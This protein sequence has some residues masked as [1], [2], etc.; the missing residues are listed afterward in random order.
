MYRVIITIFI[1][2]LNLS[3]NELMLYTAINIDTNESC[4]FY[5]E[6]Q[7]LEKSSS[8]KGQCN[9]GFIDGNVILKHH[10]GHKYIGETKNGYYHGRG[11]FYWDENHYVEGIFT[12]NYV[13]GKAKE[14]NNGY[15]FDGEFYRNAFTGFGSYTM[16]L[17]KKFVVSKGK[18]E[19]IES[20]RKHQNC[21]LNND[22]LECLV[23][24]TEI[25]KQYLPNHPILSNEYA[26]IA[27]L[28]KDNGDYNRSIHYA[29]KEFNITKNFIQDDSTIK[30]YDVLSAMYTKIND[31]ENA[32][33]YLEKSIALERKLDNQ[34]E[35]ARKYNNLATTYNTIGKFSKSLESIN[36][37]L[38]IC[39]KIYS[40]YNKNTAIAYSTRSL[41]YSSLGRFKESL[42]DAKKSL[43]IS[44]NV[45]P[46][47]MDLAIQYNIVALAY[48]KLANI[49]EAKKYYEKSLKLR[50]KLLGD[51]HPSLVNIY[52][53]LSVLYQNMGNFDKAEK[54]AKEAL[55]NNDE[56]NIHFDREKQ[57]LIYYNLATTY[58]DKGNLEKAEKYAKKSLD[59]AQAISYNSKNIADIYNVLGMIYLDKNSTAFAK[60]YMLK[61]LDLNKK[62]LTDDSPTL[63]MLY[64]NLSS[65]YKK[66]K[67]YHK[68]LI[69][70]RK[71]LEISVKIFPK[72]H[73]DLSTNYYIISQLYLELKLFDE[74]KEFAIEA[75]ESY[76]ANRKKIYSISSEKTNFKHSQNY[77]NYLDNLFFTYQRYISYYTK[78]SHKLEKITKLKSE[79][80][81]H[82]IN[83]KG[84]ITS[85]KNRLISAKNNFKSIIDTMDNLYKLEQEYTE[86]FTAI[87][88]KASFIK[89]MNTTQ[90]HLLSLKQQKEQEDEKLNSLWH[91][92]KELMEERKIDTEQIAN[93]LK[94]KELY[95]DY[96]KIDDR[97]FLFS[98]DRYNQVDFELIDTNITQLEQQIYSFRE[99]IKSKKNIKTISNQLYLSL[100]KKPIG[101]KIDE[102]NSLIISP[103]GRLSF[104]PFEAF[105]DNGKYLVQN[106]KIVYASSV[107]ELLRQKDK[108]NLIKN[109]GLVVVFANPNYDKNLSVETKFIYEK[110]TSSFIKTCAR[111]RP[112]SS[113]MA[114]MINL[115][116]QNSQELNANPI[117][118]RAMTDIYTYLDSLPY[119]EKEAKVIKSVF[120]NKAQIFVGDEAT[121]EN[122]QKISSPK[123]LHLSTHAI[124]A[125]DSKVDESFLKSIIA[126]TGY[127]DSVL[128]GYKKGFIYA[129][130]FAKLD[131][132]DTELVVFSACE[133]GLGDIRMGEG[134][135]N[136]YT[137]AI[138]AGAKRVIITLWAVADK[139]SATLMEKFYKKVDKNIDYSKALQ[140]SKKE[141]I[142]EKYH[143]FYWAGFTCNDEI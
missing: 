136:F 28:Y 63:A 48:E 141:M 100:L 7:Y 96:A 87:T 86:Y 106:K 98:V 56:V 76:I 108:E 1:L 47:S 103:D 91:Q 127:N 77:R 49:R 115:P 54:F 142:K 113:S 79:I 53:N 92:F 107:K 109:N 71:S 9:R 68:A 44:E 55:N 102:Y 23:K 83:F 89:D 66:E 104:I 3:A 8:F 82:W 69:Y 50:K 64:N 111:N 36:T 132:T 135:S 122:L 125:K 101:E 137:S 119:S 139:E 62:F 59:M 138:Q 31:L 124:F 117:D 121:V 13:S 43:V 67:N 24:K 75:F 128:S 95:I 94:E 21:L 114:T 20:I 11:K 131:L 32:S 118:L 38:K 12:K 99:A 105:F 93:L 52:N 6:K 140:E 41:I 74:A 26:F 57:S 143:P 116:D 123:I 18:H 97:Y 10:N 4:Q 78:Y 33:H 14:Y 16:P 19:I 129:E 46:N 30:R 51:N 84:T 80:F 17:G 112:V 45:S 22:L 2:F 42:V 37:S 65:I 73:P 35:M 110:N 85:D 15:I 133:T 61:S 134:V 25:T 34:E 60:T 39:K 81:N 40:K 5:E 90:S 58:K 27:S 130:D 120:K 88:S 70:A 126:F 72:N 29:L